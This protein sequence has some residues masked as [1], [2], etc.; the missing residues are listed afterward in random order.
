M[1]RLIFL[2][3]A[4]LLVACAS[5]TDECP[6]INTDMYG[7]WMPYGLEDSIY[8]RSGSDSVLLVVTEEEDEYNPDANSGVTFSSLCVRYWEYRLKG[9]D[10]DILFSLAEDDFSQAD[11][12]VNGE[13]LHFNRFVNDTLIGNKL[14]KEAAV[15]SGT[16]TSEVRSIVLEYDSGIIA[17]ETE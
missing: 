15:F 5:A 14:R 4:L 9:A 13:T 16:A 11:F 10:Y 8:V 12:I 3:S 17:L 2:L 6:P 7:P 1:K